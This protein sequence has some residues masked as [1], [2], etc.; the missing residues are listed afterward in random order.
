MVHNKITVSFNS[1]QTKGDKLTRESNSWK[2][3]E[4]KEQVKL[5][6]SEKRIW[7]RRSFVNQALRF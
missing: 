2:A 1:A 6:L 7:R 3:E 4:E 5:A